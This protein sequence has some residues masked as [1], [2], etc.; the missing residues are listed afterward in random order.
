MAWFLPPP[1][2]PKKAKLFGPWQCISFLFRNGYCQFWDRR[3]WRTGRV[4]SNCWVSRIGL[5]RMSF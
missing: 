1:W 3:L 4:H 2:L 5:C